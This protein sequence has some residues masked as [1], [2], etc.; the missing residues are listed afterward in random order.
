MKETNLVT[1]GTFP[2]VSLA[3]LAKGRLEEAGIPCFLAEENAGGLLLG[4]GASWPKIQ[5]A[6]EDAVRAI[7]VLESHFGPEEEE[8]EDQPPAEGITARDQF[9]R[10][11]DV[12]EP[13]GEANEPAE[14]ERPAADPLEA[15]RSAGQTLVWLLL[16][17][18]VGPLVL[19][20]FVLFAKLLAWAF[21]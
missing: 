21:G 5:V 13:E 16:L 7:V 11:H 6:E 14:Q 15:T 17:V 2:D 8:A 19:G 12:R 20:A 18:L 9:A 3:Y 1:V 10:F 4:V